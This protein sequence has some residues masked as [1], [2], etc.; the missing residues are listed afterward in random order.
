MATVMRKE[1]IYDAILRDV[2]EIRNPHAKFT[3]DQYLKLK[4]KVNNQAKKDVST[5]AM[6]L[7]LQSKKAFFELTTARNRNL[8]NVD[9]QNKLRKTVVGFFGLSVGSLAALTWMRQSRA[10]V[11][12]IMDPDTID[13]TNL[14]RI[15]FGWDTIG[16]EKAEVV[17]KELTQI[18]P[19]CEVISATKTDKN[20]VKHFFF[21]KPE[22]DIIIDAIDDFEGKVLLRYFAK[23]RKIALVSAADVGD[24]VM[25]DIERY[26]I[27]PRQEFFHGRVEDLDKINF[28]QLT[29]RE[30]KK[31][32]IQLVGFENASERMIESIMAIGG[33][34]PT[35]PQLGAT[36]TMAGGIVT[37][38]IKKIILGEQV[39]SGRYYISLDDILVKDFNS[40]RRVTERKA[41][42]AQIERLLNS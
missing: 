19:F 22:L 33:S 17:K 32:I 40:N 4:E 41:K 42:V 34:I 31:L 28:S 6:L 7:P 25:L 2:F 13:A 23:K 21:A 30:R 11:I 15:P 18:N 8:I 20:T 35:W 3:E 26:D 16:R 29:D 24:N 38:A 9:E 5:K 39:E 27:N 36:A 1:N 14:N 10:D 37:T 12:K